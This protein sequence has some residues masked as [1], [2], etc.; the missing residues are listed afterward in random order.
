MET[1]E[2]ASILAWIE[3]EGGHTLPPFTIPPCVSELCRMAL[4]TVCAA[5][6]GLS[7]PGSFLPEE[8][9]RECGREAI[10]PR[11]KR[12]TRDSRR[13]WRPWFVHAPKRIGRRDV[14]RSER[15]AGRPGT[16]APTGE[17][18]ASARNWAGCEGGKGKILRLISR[19]WNVAR[20]PRVGMLAQDDKTEGAGRQT[21]GRPAGKAGLDARRRGRQ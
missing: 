13:G 14:R 5:G 15:R 6:R 7:P 9:G 21:D 19:A 20:F 18:G 12:R 10:P 1:S 3:P 11:R 4:S 17:G 8:G 2:K 16:S